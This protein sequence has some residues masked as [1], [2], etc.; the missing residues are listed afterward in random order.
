M[1]Q[2]LADDFPSYATLKKWVAEFKRG[3][4]ATEDDPRLRHP[5][6]SNT[7]EQDDAIHRL[8]L[9]YRRLTVH[10]IAKSIGII[11]CSVHTI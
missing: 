7:D 9:V 2:I 10:Q 3:R 4:D 5:K 8:S 11:S 1:V 6:T